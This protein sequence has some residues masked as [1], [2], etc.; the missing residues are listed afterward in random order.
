MRQ[1]DKGKWIKSH[2]EVSPELNVAPR[3]SFSRLASFDLVSSCSVLANFRC[4]ALDS[5]AH[6]K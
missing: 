4:A 1:G 5:V 3:S 2:V 6:E